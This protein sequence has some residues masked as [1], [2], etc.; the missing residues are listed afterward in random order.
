VQTQH[1]FP[2]QM[3]MWGVSV[4]RSPELVCSSSELHPLRSD[5]HWCSHYCRSVDEYGCDQLWK[6]SEIKLCTHDALQIQRW[7]G[8]F[9]GPVLSSPQETKTSSWW[10]HPIETDKTHR[11][12]FNVV[13][14]ELRTFSGCCGKRLRER[15]RG[16]RNSVALCDGRVKKGRRKKDMTSSVWNDFN[17]SL[18]TGPFR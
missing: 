8:S 15:E 1:Q 6:E 12:L 13:F 4:S 2:Q 3:Q 16:N 9:S 5:W 18:I 17:S 11:H 14:C 10:K 7:N